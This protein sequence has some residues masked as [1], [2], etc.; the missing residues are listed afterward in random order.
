MKQHFE[1][2]ISL[3]IVCFKVAFVKK[4]AF[5]VQRKDLHY[6]D[7]VLTCFTEMLYRYWPFGRDTAAPEIL[8]KPK[9]HI[10]IIIF[11]VTRNV[12]QQGCSPHRSFEKNFK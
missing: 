6:V 1:I 4:P 7:A 8:R 10:S 11:F 3:D 12:R 5:Y 2:L 9:I